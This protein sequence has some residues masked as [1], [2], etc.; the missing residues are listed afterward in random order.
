MKSA[1]TIP[2]SL[3]WSVSLLADPLRLGR[4]H[5]FG[6]LQEVGV[7]GGFLAILAGFYLRGR[8][9]R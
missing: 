6:W 1:A 5:G 8:A 3:H 2:P 4:Y 9:S 7:I